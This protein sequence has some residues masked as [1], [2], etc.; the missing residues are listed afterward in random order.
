VHEFADCCFFTHTKQPLTEMIYLS[1]A[2]CLI[3]MQT[4]TQA[5][6]YFTV[7]EDAVTKKTTNRLLLFII[8]LAVIPRIYIAFISGLPQMHVDTVGYFEQADAILKGNYINYFPNGYPFLAAFAKLT[9]GSSFI[10]VLLIINIITAAASV[11]FVFDITKNVFQNSRIAIIAALLMTIFPTQINYVRWLLTEVPSTFFLLGFYFFYFRNKNLAAGMM[12]GIAAIIRTEMLPIFLLTA[13]AELLLKRRIRLLLMIGVAIPI[14]AVSCYSYFKTGQFT[15]S[16]H[17]KVNILYAITSSGGYVDWEFQDKHPEIKNSK[18]AMQLYLQYLKDD[19][20]TFI[21]N[22]FLNLWELWS[23][24][25]SASDGNRGMASRIM[26]G[27][28]NFFLLSFGFY[29]AWKNR[30]T[31]SALVLLAPFIVVTGVHFVLYSL[32]RYT[33][34]VEPFMIILSAFT[35]YQ[36]FLFATGRNEKKIPA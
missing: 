16:G 32:T 24:F 3:I 26:I 35:V 15:T 10:I 21:K 31:I 20:G 30:K 17:G 36:L 7:N 8:I 25:P 29:S 23:F 12:M 4:I 27:L 14:L 22:R 34:T 9:G 11:F 13:G 33:F 6:H 19:P 1:P 2:K 5:L 18:E 28:I